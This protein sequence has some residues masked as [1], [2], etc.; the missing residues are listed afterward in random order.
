MDA[1]FLAVEGF[2]SNLTFS[3][4]FLDP[5]PEVSRSEGGLFRLFALRMDCELSNGVKGKPSPGVDD[6]ETYNGN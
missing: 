6:V 3:R 5:S 1:Q 4:F 2:S